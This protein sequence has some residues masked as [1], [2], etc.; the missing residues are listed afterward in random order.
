MKNIGDV[1]EPPK[2]AFTFECSYCDERCEVEVLNHKSVGKNCQTKDKCMFNISTA[3]KNAV[4][5][6]TSN[7]EVD[8][9]GS[10]KD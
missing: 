9:E 2:R 4:A 5:I 1:I 10:E 8:D 7:K 3:M 6:F